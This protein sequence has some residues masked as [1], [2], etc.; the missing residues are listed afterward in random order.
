MNRFMKVLVLGGAIL[1]ESA[2][3][4]P[5]M[6][7]NGYVNCGSCHVS[8]TGGG[9]LNEYGR[10]IIREKLAIFKSPNEKSKEHLFAYGVLSDTPLHKAILAGGDVRSVY[11]YRNDADSIT[12]KTYFMQGDLEVARQ[13]KRFTADVAIGVEQPV[14]GENLQFISRRHYLQYALSDSWGLRGGK[15]FPAYGIKTPDHVSLTRD[16]LELGDN[17]ESYNLELSYITEAWA[18]FA[19]GIFGRFDHDRDRQDRGFALQGSYAPLE[20]LRL[21]LNVWHG[22]QPTRN[23]TLLGAFSLW[24]ITHEL[25]FQN[26]IDLQFTSQDGIASTQKLSYELINGL[27]VFV[28]QEYGKFDFSLESTK[29]ETYGIGIQIFPR[30][31]FEFNL[32]YEK[33]RSGGSGVPFTDYAW[34]MSHFY[35]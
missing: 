5:E 12:G 14:P 7:R 6:I 4:F 8:Q 32:A 21:G 33:L 29:N 25:S 24:G 13:E 30:A 2:Y 1:T 28:Q 23:R 16:P 20:H 18:V 15:Y 31:H 35:F 3:G 22:E 34:F 26:E 11:V 17:F 27:W 19:T 10:E 9:L